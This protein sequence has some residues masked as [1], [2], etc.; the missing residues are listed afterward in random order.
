MICQNC[1]N[2]NEDGSSFC[3]KCGVKLVI[4]DATSPLIQ[5][6]PVEPQPLYQSSQIAIPIKKKKY[7][8]LWIL[9]AVVLLIGGALI[10][11]FGSLSWFPPK[12]LG[13]KYTKV[14]Y[15]SFVRKVGLENIRIS[16]NG[17]IDDNNYNY[18]LSGSKKVN[19]EITQEELTAYVN[20]GIPSN[21]AL[22]KVQIRI[23]KD[24][25]LEGS[26]V[27][28]FDYIKSLAVKNNAS[29]D[30]LKI[31]I[32]LPEKANIYIKI[33]ASM[34]DNVPDITLCE[35]YLGTISVKSMISKENIS[36]AEQA[37]TTLL[38][39]A[40]PTLKINS[41]KFADGKAIVDG[42]M[43]EKI[44]RVLKTVSPTFGYISL[45]PPKTVGF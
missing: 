14:D 12:D 33:N 37:L 6:T 24:G 25:S 44:E 1:G 5:Q 43:P 28:N 21:L 10:Y 13:V 15:E 20:E 22:D 34:T 4:P 35:G 11:F 30:F 40:N 45:K 19:A 17:K 38:N 7:I 8:G 41:I 36:M 18:V 39:N 31:P 32:P 3:V 29:V 9:L 26:G 16:A 42:Q 23:N 2:S 27:V